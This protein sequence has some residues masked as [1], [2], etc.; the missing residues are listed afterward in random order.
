MLII[1]SADPYSVIFG[2][3]ITADI[4]TSV[5]PC[6]PDLIPVCTGDSV[7]GD[8]ACGKICF[9]PLD[10][11]IVTGFLHCCFYTG[12]S[13]RPEEEDGDQKARSQPLE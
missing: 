7:P 11:T 1:K 9:V 5:R 12:E 13:K 8:C 3:E 10:E 6:T 2:F 4:V